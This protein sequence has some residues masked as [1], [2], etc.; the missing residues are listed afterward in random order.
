MEGEKVEYDARSKQFDIW[1]LIRRSNQTDPYILMAKHRMN[2]SP[3]KR[4]KTAG[5]LIGRRRRRVS[6]AESVDGD[7]NRSVASLDMYDDGPEDFDFDAEEE[8]HDMR[9]PTEH[10]QDM[11]VK[12]CKE[13]GVH[14]VANFHHAL[15]TDKCVLRH[16]QMTA[17]EIKAIAVALVGNGSIETLDLSDNDMGP[18]GTEYLADA[19]RE[20]T[21]IRNLGLADNN[22]GAEGVKCIVDIIVKQDTVNS[23]S[24][25][26]NGLRECDAEVIRPLIENTIHLKHLD[27]SHNQ[28]REAGGEMIG[29]ALLYNDTMESLDLSWN[30]LR[31]DGACFIADGLSENICLKK[32]NIAWNG[33]YLDGCKALA[34][35]LEENKTLTELDLTCNRV[36]KECLEK[37][38][39]GLKRN[40]TLEIL[41]LGWNPI[42]PQGAM[43]ILEFLR[44]YK[45]SGIKELDLTDQLVEP[46]FVALLGEIEATRELK[47]VFGQVKG[48]DTRGD[49]DDEKQLMDENPII[50]LM[51]FGKLMG[52]RLMDLFAA[53]DKDGSK[54]LDHDE[55]R[56]GLRMVN[57]PLSD[58]CIEVLI[59]KLDVDGDG[60]IDFGEL[61]AAQTEHRKKMSKFYAAQEGDVDIEDT[62]IGR[63]RIKLSRLMAKKM[64]GNPAFK[65]SVEQMKLLLHEQEGQQKFAEK[66]TDGLAQ[67]AERAASKIPNSSFSEKMKVWKPM[68][69]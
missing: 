22:L 4:A 49:D 21:F 68:S 8:V 41:R 50:V 64:S 66:M 11:Y 63:V 16:R 18:K 62:E 60:E 6:T 15:K 38:I 57:I 40:T 55:I 67:R 25:A 14:P 3:T 44:D 24:I 1:G 47:V 31:R 13:Y 28:L 26:G 58:K 35:A 33:F 7:S 46:A 59:N 54:S 65:R 42:T 32:L 10:C 17:D 9:T 5:K 20:N 61:M 27:I 19:L 53:L 36:S 45:S 2:K 30:H 48:Q 69:T 51:E 23:L 34:K 12:A 37:L 52:F 29:E 43:T 39:G 56:T